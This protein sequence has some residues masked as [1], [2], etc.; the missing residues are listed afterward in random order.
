M[1][2]CVLPW[3]V[4]SLAALGLAGCGFVGRPERPAWR[5]Q[6]EN[7]CFARDL[8][9]PSAF[10]VPSRAIDGPGICGMTRPLKVSALDDGKVGFDKTLTVDCPMTAALEAWL[11]DVVQPAAQARL[12]QRVVT[13]NVFGAYSCRSIDNEPGAR[14][15]EHAFGNAVDV[16]GFT[17][18]DGRTL[19]YVRDWKS[20]GTQEAAFLHEAHAGACQVFTTVL[21]PGSDV[22][23][24]NHVHVDLANH[25][26]TNTG[27]RRI[28]KPAP[29]P[30]LLPPPAAPDSLPPAP[31]IEE[32]LDIARHGDPRAV[33]LAPASLAPVSLP[34]AAIAG[35]GAG[36]DGAL[37]PPVGDMDPVPPV[38]PKGAGYSVDSSPT[39]SI[40][41]HDE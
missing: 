13:V 37:P 23:H 9:K 16:A 3:I 2:R 36:P 31:E 1:A 28:C 40:A 17:L 11:D 26:S 8:V 12:G 21:G 32:P 41:D 15:S 34:P 4:A 7:A 27:P 25:G 38:L 24:Y 30:N 5:A 22:F 18:A 20:A 29:Q 19:L 14:L 10:V 6:A 33:A 35:P 39:S